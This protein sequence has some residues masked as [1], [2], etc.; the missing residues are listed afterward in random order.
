MEETAMRHIPTWFGATALLAVV[1]FG[2]PV[3]GDSGDKPMKEED[4]NQKVAIHDATLKAMGARL[5]SIDKILEKI[6]NRL[7][8]IEDSS[9]RR[10]F[11]EP[12][13]EEGRR[14]DE[15]D[16]LRDEVARLREDRTR[17]QRR[18]DQLE[19]DLRK[20]RSFYEGPGS[21]GGTGTVAIENQ[22]ATWTAFVT[23]NGTTY[24]LAPGQ[25]KR[26]DNVPAGDFTYSITVTNS[27]GQ[28]SVT[29]PTKTV[30]LRARNTFT[31]TI[32]PS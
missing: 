27:L 31:I 7:A 8:R 24:T 28:S 5:K 2:A 32:N 26:L 30:N 1:L 22:N 21:I 17:M 4:L 19:D 15:V 25:G 14:R 6:E 18:I 23:V 9:S 3:R 16:R 11:Y 10:S 12:G 13:D 29:Q 20:R